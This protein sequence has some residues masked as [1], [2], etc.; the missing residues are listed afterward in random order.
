MVAAAGPADKNVAILKDERSIA[1]I[2]K[3]W[4]FPVNEII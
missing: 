3:I 1:K 4:L 2:I